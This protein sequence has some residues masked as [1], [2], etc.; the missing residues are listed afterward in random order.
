[1]P[2]MRYGNGVNSTSGENTIRHYYDRAG[3]KAANRVNVFQQFADKRNMPSSHGKTYKVSKWQHM[4]DREIA[5]PEFSSKG[6]LSARTVDEVSA[7]LLNAQIAEGAGAVNKRVMK[8]ITVETTLNRYGEM[9]DY[10]DEVE[11]FSEDSVQTRYREELAAL[12]NSRHEDLIMMDMLATGTVMYAGPAISLNTIGAGVA[13]NGE[14][15]STYKVSY[16]LIRRGVRLLVR[17]RAKKNTQLVSGDVK[18]DT[19]TVPKAFYAI[20]GAD[21]KADLENLTRGKDHSTEYVYV[22]AHKYASAGNIAEG[23]VGAMHEVRFVE[24]EGM[25]IYADE[26]AAA[27]AAYQ[28]NLA[29]GP[30]GK[31]NAYPIL[32]PTEGCFATVGLKGRDK[33]KF[34]SKAPSEVSNGNPYGTSGFFSYNMFYAGLITQEE[35]LLKI[36]VAASE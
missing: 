2:Q 1:M 22:P 25:A 27:P 28:G 14:D 17:N 15:D 35:R 3:I 5:D 13:A 12:A 21:V 26:G 20:I 24:S 10:T 34:H 7:T 36:L 9:M 8:K 30:T 29:V 16:D 31:F 6:Y 4:Y 32:F 33:I 23:E 19:R 11:L 18:V